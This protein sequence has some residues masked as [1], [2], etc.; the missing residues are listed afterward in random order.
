MINA[1][2]FVKGFTV[3]GKAYCFTIMTNNF[4]VQVFS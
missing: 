4:A 2:L 3:K 1:F